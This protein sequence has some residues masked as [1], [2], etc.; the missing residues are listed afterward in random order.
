MKRREF[1][2]A[3][4]AA[5][6]VTLWLPACGSENGEEQRPEIFEE[7]HT[8]F[9]QSLAS[10]DPRPDSVI[11]WTRVQDESK[12]ESNI[13][14]E[15]QVAED[16]AFEAMVPLG[17][18]TSLSVT[19]ESKYDHC[20]KVRLTALS[21]YT[22]YYY[23]FIYRRDEGAYTSKTGR[24]RTAPALESDASLRFAF[25]ACQDFNGRYYNT[26]ARLAQQDFDFFVHLG[27]YV[28]ETNGNP[29]FQDPT[30]ERRVQFS[31]PEE[32]IAFNLGSETEYY[33]ARSLGN[34]RDLYKN[35]R[36]DAD[37]QRIHEMAPMIAIWDDHEFSNDCYGA[38]ATYSNER[39]NEYDVDRRKAAN[40]AWFEYMPVDYMDEPDFS[41]D[42]EAEYPKDIRIYRDFVFGKN[43]HLVMTDLRSYRSPHVIGQGT[44]PGALIFNQKELDT[45]FDS[46]PE[47]AKAYVDIEDYEDGAYKSLLV[48]RAEELDHDP[49]RI[50]GNIRVDFINEEIE[51]LREMNIETG[52][53]TIAEDASMELGLAFSD[54]GKSSSF[55]DLGAIQ[56]A[57]T[58]LYRQYAK[59]LYEESEGASEAGMGPEQEAWFLETME[60]SER[61]WKVW[62]NE[63]CL[64]PLNVDLRVATDLPESFQKVFTLITEDWNGQP[65]RRAM[66][67]DKLADLENVVAITGDV[68]SFYAGTPFA[69][70]ETREKK[71]IEFVGG[72]IS[73][74]V[75]ED[76]LVGTAQSDPTLRDAGAVSLAFLAEEFLLDTYT[77]VNPHLGFADLKH[78]GFAF[79]E[80][81]SAEMKVTFHA[82]DKEAAKARIP[83][84]ELSERFKTTQFKVLAGASE[85]LKLEEDAWKIWDPEEMAWI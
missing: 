39:E 5:A 34:Y 43:L 73:S 49:T 63:Y 24:T 27:D 53:E 17:A 59:K 55:S 7:E 44:L 54:L 30:K 78:N 77:R 48:E 22:T 85:L 81:D 36:S 14:I 29:L 50:T 1:L 75:L 45:R 32:A 41:Y 46:I 71:I 62:G 67:L 57:A 58:E 9:P 10:G 11:L 21:A 26:Y 33:A 60:N 16:P 42:P 13:A 74:E 2:K 84:P 64:V 19:A 37:L 20:V 40:Q 18:D 25:M 3:T 23:R 80:I 72:S 4:I 82:I 47:A 68:H 66:L 52:L 28:Y 6:G 8:F 51:R 83:E 35:Y 79:V 76:E 31:A 70:P 12:S 38:T 56:L 61:V 69:D 65:N 15:L